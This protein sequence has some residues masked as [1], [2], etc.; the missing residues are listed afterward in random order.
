MSDRAAMLGSMT[1]AR[2]I[3]IPKGSAGTFHCVSRCVRRAY[4]CGEDRL[5][6]RSFEHR[7]QWLEDRIHELAG[8]F[9]VAIW[10]YAVMSN[11]LHVVV[12]ILPEVVSRWSNA[13]IV[14][15]WMRLYPR[16]DQNPEI[17]AEALVGNVERIKELRE[18]LSN[19][20]WFMRCLVEPIARAANKE[21]VCKGRFWEGRFKAQ[22]LLD[23]NAVLAAMAYVDLNPVRAKICDTL[24]AS[25]HTSARER[26]T[27]IEQQSGAADRPLAPIAGIR[28]MCV[29]QMTQAEYLNLVDYTGR[30]IRADKRGTLE[31]Q[32]P[33]ALARL[34]YRSDTWTRQVL[35]VK[36]DFSR[37][38][39]AVECL[40][41]KAAEMGQCWLRGI[42]TA[43][44]LAAR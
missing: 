37:A 26:L 32:P 24:E 20:S 44:W 9:G 30:Q 39:G 10:G 41:A 23:D 14:E 7:R 40:I 43:R 2:S 8:I 27:E 31:G 4:L 42:A 22:C 21:D 35:A 1:Y 25:V 5:T 36:S 16:Q 34:G 6:G 15:R 38:M 17:R 12:Q 28:G 11:H 19:L 13:E 29:L 3:L 18:R 33:A